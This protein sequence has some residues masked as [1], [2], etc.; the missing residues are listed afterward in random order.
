MC[1]RTEYITI[2]MLIFL[3]VQ[4][5]LLFCHTMVTSGYKKTTQLSL[6]VYFPKQGR[7]GGRDILG[8]ERYIGLI[9]RK[10][11]SHILG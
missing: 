10:W 8:T 5:N 3:F 4:A 6:E 7:G 9:L 1:K 2:H 11:P